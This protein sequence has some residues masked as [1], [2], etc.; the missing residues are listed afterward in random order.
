LLD[1]DTITPDLETASEDYARRF[2]GPTGRYFLDSQQASLIGLLGAPTGPLRVLELGGGHGQLAP[3][4]LAVGHEVWVQGSAAVCA[5]RL[6]PLLADRPDRLRFVVSSLWSLPFADRTFDVVLA[7]RLLAHVERCPELLQE[8]ARLSRRT[9]IVDFP[10]RVS[11]NLLEP[12]LFALKRRL[13]GNTRPFFCY[14]PRELQAPLARAGFGRFRLAK[15]FTLPMVVHRTLRAPGLSAALE[16][17]CRWLGL[18][19]LLGT[20]CLL[21]AERLDAAPEQAA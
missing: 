14:R 15:Q 8:M 21:A 9:V 12:A 4:L 17:G 16:G 11:A 1:H 3:A 10:A 7:V 13:E 2:A 20:P 6:G 18:T 5:R 19:A